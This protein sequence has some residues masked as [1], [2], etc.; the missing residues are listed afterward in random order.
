MT[1]DQLIQ[2]ALGVACIVLAAVFLSGK[3][4]LMLMV[5]NFGAMMLGRLIPGPGQV[6]ERQ[7]ARMA[8]D[9]VARS[10]SDP[11]PRG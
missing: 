10:L 7:A 9:A 5:S 4:E 8:E 3:P 6:T 2:G 11:P 1:R